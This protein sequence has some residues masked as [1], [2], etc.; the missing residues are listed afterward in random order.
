M[1]HF[2][3]IQV[4]NVA[5]DEESYIS[6]SDIFEDEVFNMNADYG[7]EP[8]NDYDKAMSDIKDELKD[9]A[10]V[11]TLKRTITFKNKSSVRKVYAEHIRKQN[12][13]LRE[14]LDRAVCRHYAFRRAVDEVCYCRDL[15]HHGYCQTSS[16]LV[17]DYLNGHLGRTLHIGAILDAQY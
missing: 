1:G 3:I 6:D 8:V 17:E 2:K 12:K 7:G 4:S 10:T 16:S 15:F 11:D 9:I 5:I 14:E 13:W